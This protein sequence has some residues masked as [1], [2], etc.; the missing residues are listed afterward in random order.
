M[1][2]WRQCEATGDAI[3]DYED[4]SG[5]VIPLRIP[6]DARMDSIGWGR[7]PRA[8]WSTPA[9]PVE[10]LIVSEGDAG[11]LARDGRGQLHALPHGSF[12]LRE[13]PKPARI[14]PMAKAGRVWVR[15]HQRD[16]H[17]V[18][19]HWRELAVGQHYPLPERWGGG[20]TVRPD[21]D[22]DGTTVVLQHERGSG[23]PRMPLASVP[24][25]VHDLSEELPPTSDRSGDASVDSVL[26]G[27]A[28][29]IAKGNDGIVYQAATGEA[30][31][32]STTVPYQPHNPGH[33]TPEGAATHL[34]AEKE[35]HD[36]LR[37]LPH[38]PPVRGIQHGDR[39]YLV[40]PWAPDAVPT[41]AEADSIVKT[42]RSM[43]DMG[44][45]LNDEI[46]VG[47]TPDGKVYLTDLGQARANATAGEFQDERAR[48]SHWLRS[49][50]LKEPAPTGAELVKRMRVLENLTRG[51]NPNPARVAEWRD[52]H[53]RRLAELRKD[54][55]AWDAEYDRGAAHEATWKGTEPMAKADR[56]PIPAGARWITVRPNGPGT[57]GHPIL[58]VPAGDGTH[59]VIG[60]AGGS[61]NHLRLRDVKSED[62][63]RREAGERRQAKAARRKAMTKEERDAEDRATE[64]KR[65][66]V[67][68]AERS[69]VEVVRQ[70]WGGVDDDLTDDQ[71][72]GLSDKARKRMEN[73]HHRRQFRQAM[74][75]R[76]DIAGKLAADRIDQIE[77]EA[78]I[79]AVLRQEPDTFHEARR[80][81]EAEL[82]LLAEEDEARRA[83]R[84]PRGNRAVAE[85]RQREAAAT[86][87]T[88]LSTVN[89]DDVRTM[90]EEH[91]G[92]RQPGQPITT[93]TASEEQ[94]RRAAQLL[95][96][97]T[98][99]ADAAA[100]APPSPDPERAALEV[101]TIADALARAGVDRDDPAAVEEALANEARIALERAEL[102]K[103]RATKFRELEAE[104]KGKQ[105]IRALVAADVQRGLSQEVRDAAERLG[106]RGDSSVPLREAEVAD[107]LE[108]L[109][110]F[111]KLRAAKKGLEEVDGK[112]RGPDSPTYDKSRRAFDLD[113]GPAAADALE[114]V[115]EEVR[116]ELATRILGVADS[117]SS[118]HAQAVGDGHYAKLADVSLAI[119]GTNY[120]SRQ[121][122]DA[123]GVKNAAVLLRHALT[124][125]GHDPQTVG[126]T[127]V[128]HHVRT[129]VK[130]TA[131]AL[132]AAE[133][134]IPGIEETV[135]SVGDVRHA[136]AKLGARELDI[137]DAQTAIGSALGQMEATAT[138]AQ[139]MKGKTPES[140]TLDMRDGSAAGSH[141]TWLHSIGL[142]PGEYELDTT[143]KTITIPASSWHRLIQKED[144]ATIQ[145]R[146]TAQA[147]KRGEQDEQGWLPQGFVSRSS[148]SFTDPPDGAP[149]YHRPL[150]LDASDIQTELAD[151]VG[152]RLLD[153]ER[154]ADIATDLLSPAVA[155]M[156]PDPEAFAGLVRELFPIHTDDDRRALESNAENE[157]ARGAL[158]EQYH[159]AVEAGDTERVAD[160]ARQIA[161]IPRPTEVRPKRDVDFPDHYEALAARA[162]RGAGV[163]TL[164]GRS[165]YEGGVSDRDVSEAVFR[166]LGDDPS[167]AAAFA[168]LGELEGKH[169]DALQDYFYKRAGIADTR[170]WS[171][172]FAERTAALIE[173]INT[174]KVAGGNTGRA[175]EAAG[176][177]GMFGGGM[178]G[179]GAA[180]PRKDLTPETLA[181][182]HPEHAKALAMEYPREGADLF[183]A[184]MGARPPDVDPASSK[185][186]PDV[187]AAI[188]AIR[189]RRPGLTAPAELAREA[190]LHIGRQRALKEAGL[191]E[192]DINTSDPITGAL[193]PKAK[194]ARSKIEARAA[195]LQQRGIDPREVQRV[196]G[197]RLH[198]AELA[199]F[200]AHRQRHATP[201][202][203]FVDTH[204]GQAG[205]YTALQQELRGE[206][207]QKFATHY[208]RITKRP[209]Q[210]QLAEVPNAELHA[211][212]ITS[213]AGRKELA[214]ARRAEVDAARGRGAA[215]ERDESGRALGGKFRE[216]SALE[217]YRAAKDEERS[218]AQR[219]GG[220][221][222]AAPPAKARVVSTTAPAKRGPR[223][224]ERMA[225]GSRM[226]DEIAAVI[227]GNLGKNIDPTSKIRV[228]PGASMDGKR[229]AQQRVIKMIRANKRVVAALGPGSGKTPTAIGAFTDLHTAGEATHGLFLVPSAVQSQFGEE[230]HS[231]AEPGKYRFETGGGKSHHE[232]V[233]MLRDKNVHMRVLT[234]QS[235]TRTFLRV[236]A[237]HYGVAPEAML[238]RLRGQDDRERAQTMRAALD[239]AGIP[240]H[241]TNVDEFHGITTRQGQ[242]ETDTAIVLGAIAHPTNS[243]Y[244]ML[245]SGTPAKNDTS[246]IRSVARLVDPDKYGGKAYQF[247]QAYGEGSVAAPDALRRELE[248]A[249][250]TDSI[251]PDGVSR[252]D[253]ANPE[254]RDGRKVSTGP[255]QLDDAHAADVRA[256]EETYKRAS[257]SFARDGTV[258][259][260]AV[261]MLSPGRFRDVPPDQHEAIARS[262]APHLDIV[263]ETAMRRALQ[264][265]PAEKNAKLR[266]M[267]EVVDHDVRNNKPGLI[268]TDSAEEAHH[269]TQELV[270]RGIAAGTYH[271][272][273]GEKERD[274]FR[275]DFQAGKLKVG[276][277]TAAG[278]A[279]INL[280]T[281][282]TIHH[283]DVPKTAKSWSQ[284]NGRAYRIGQKG[285][286]DV[287]DW[288]FDHEHEHNASRTLRNKGRL[289]EIMQTPLGAL[290]EHGIAAE[291][292][293]RQMQRH[294]TFDAEGLLAAK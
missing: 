252:I 148:T 48:L 107:M 42:I 211:A 51:P 178:F 158:T 194:V 229:I 155:G 195:D 189:E 9:G 187:H 111:D 55:D 209:L 287:H 174:G 56:K 81:A 183:R 72:A 292:R 291:Y 95:D 122:V 41:Q 38:I 288:T 124:Q 149:R 270:R 130:L 137:A 134:L 32:V 89:R 69:V 77:D 2:T 27:G 37:H 52:L 108:I 193:T 109:Q 165:L 99:L 210:T 24:G 199:A 276:V 173:D 284:R 203:S 20:V 59:R 253:T 256:V 255:I 98:I 283:Y 97:A 100:G 4:D 66:A 162:A 45:T 239:A 289:S 257:E 227:G 238:E 114:T 49:H 70:R 116:R 88:V 186:H 274:A 16:G 175:A 47:R 120:L 265:A 220:L 166:A 22:G 67:R 153:G 80:M 147:L 225:L 275:R 128:A 250:Y 263:K 7:R 1:D 180:P 40:K 31:K 14:Q 235:A 76:K 50:G 258:D 21:P 96:D 141:L 39:Y 63:L 79:D 169:R 202:A 3:L 53:S 233:A 280:Q 192:A 247:A 197:G 152:A 244:V 23:R 266:R 78:A 232:R 207:V 245:G 84:T 150:N 182:L 93:T 11:V 159:A 28:K 101:E 185:L 151:H 60:G 261:R 204:G 171:K 259:V 172:E 228:F 190:A 177:G 54:P 214:A 277:M 35:A 262:L 103:A 286:V 136:M 17:T 26:S 123:L 246:E 170:S 267:L 206:F 260:D 94:T 113:I 33:R 74:A 163:D 226:E 251:P 248:H 34:R 223:P 13:Y 143:A 156:S 30:V 85:E 198:D 145:G 25:Y 46:Q 132:E 102:A 294:Q 285:D 191:T 230:I 142:H 6:W 181:E 117:T 212:A 125:D 144:A 188:D 62:Q 167:A 118:A 168:P 290:D 268:F 272:G 19:G 234:H 184:A 254:I 196:Y 83:V 127:L 119:A 75:A 43:H 138:M 279:G 139:A 146:K 104:G 241:F 176:Q 157:R 271:G 273:L 68:K 126:D 106:L 218:I 205:A 91:G 90:L 200:E 221:F 208:G 135:T 213:P 160:L 240:Q 15:T 281:A 5:E 236:A 105:A 154:P 12:K 65:S 217:R 219:Q 129:Q 86:A 61:M 82:H 64:E 278:E 243:P 215:G 58:V 10:A 36:A 179:G 133:L 115:E 269:V 224:G 231:F 29:R 92:R 18:E 249:V 44:W 140:I 293:Q 201:W 57:E 222:G 8:T 216:G 121:V 237:D 164:N 282:K 73:A 161:A 242:Q 71:F 110:S 131:D 112:V 87:R 264:L